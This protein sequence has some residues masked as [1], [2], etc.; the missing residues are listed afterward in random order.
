[1]R[2]SEGRILTTHAGSLP[3]PPALVEALTRLNRREAVD[4]AEFAAM[5]DD[6]VSDVVRRQVEV[7]VDIGNDGEQGRESFFT[8]VQHRMSGFGGQGD[9]PRQWRDVD[10]FPGFSAIRRAQRSANPQV[11][12]TR[13]PKAVGEVRYLDDAAVAADCERLRRPAAADPRLAGPPAPPAE[14]SSRRS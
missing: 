7:G 5:V 8:Y 9:A 14:D 2:R 6:A 3:R 13:P 4:R 10:D 11:T 12:L 1:M